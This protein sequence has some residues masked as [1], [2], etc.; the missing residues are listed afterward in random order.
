MK[1]MIFGIAFLITAMAIPPLRAAEPPSP[2]IAVAANFTGAMEKI[3][4][5]YEKETGTRLQMVYS[6]TGKLYAQIKN[7]APYDLFLA[8]DARRPELLA[9]EGICEE[10]FIYATG[11]AVLWTGNAALAG[12]KGWQEVIARGEVGKIAISSPETAPYGAAAL[13]AL[14][15]AG[16]LPLVEDKL[17]Y[18]QNVAQA[19]QFANS[20][21]AGLGFTALS[22]ARSDQGRIGIFWPIPEAEAVV[23]K[24]CLIKNRNSEE[25]VKALLAFLHRE[26]ARAILTEYGYK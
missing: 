9:E 22:L 11:A 10:P 17:V 13:A 12:I 7:G 1:S 3:G 21:S 23:Q 14:D 24:G 4:A 8:A 6:S 5:A 26:N 16:L 2:I 20:G 25:S 19:F 15:K 18:G